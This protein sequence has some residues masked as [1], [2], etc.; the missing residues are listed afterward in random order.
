MAWAWN[1][2]AWPA[3]TALITDAMGTPSS[4]YGVAVKTHFGTQL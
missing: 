4:P 2:A 3:C 1:F